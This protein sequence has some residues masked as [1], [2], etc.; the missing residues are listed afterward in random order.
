[1][2][3]GAPVAFTGLAAATELARAGFTEVVVTG[4]RPDL[5]DVARRRYLPGAVLAW[6]EPY[7]SPLWEGKTEPELADLAF[8]CDDYTC[9]PPTADPDILASQLSS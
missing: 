1:M 8:V 7:E 4:D 9:Q 2:I 6:G 5:L 3:I